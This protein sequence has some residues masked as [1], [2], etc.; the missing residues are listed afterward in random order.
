MKALRELGDSD[1]VSGC[2][3]FPT[4]TLSKYREGMINKATSTGDLQYTVA[5]FVVYLKSTEA[6]FFCRLSVVFEETLL[7]KGR[8]YIVHCLSHPE[9]INSS[10]IWWLGLNSFADSLPLFCTVDQS[11]PMHPSLR[12]QYLRKNEWFN[13]QLTKEMDQMQ[14]ALNNTNDLSLSNL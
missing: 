14:W 6:F 3:S 1:I 4:G 8:E 9:G 5:S 10:M 12:F 13:L 7:T 2:I 11:C